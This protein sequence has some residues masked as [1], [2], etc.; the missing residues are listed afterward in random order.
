MDDAQA[1][2]AGGARFL[3]SPVAPPGPAEEAQ[4]RGV[5]MILGGLTPS[6]IVTALGMGADMVK[7][8]PVASLGGPRYIRMLL[9]PFPTLPLMVSGG[10]TL[11]DLAEYQALGVQT[12]ALGDALLPRDLV[13]RGDWKEVSALAR[14]AVELTRQP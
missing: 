6:E 7:V 1:A 12:V 5:P 14:Q 11:G 8:W 2:L 10:T 13:N 3:V 4:R 9:G